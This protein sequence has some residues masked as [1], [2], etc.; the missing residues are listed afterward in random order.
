MTATMKYVYPDMLD[1]DSIQSMTN[2][3]LNLRHNNKNK[4][5]KFNKQVKKIRKEWSGNSTYSISA[6]TDKIGKYHIVSKS[7]C[8]TYYQQNLYNNHL[9]VIYFDLK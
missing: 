6:M 3:N 5:K 1:M 9:S 2:V 8:G 7:K 4:Y